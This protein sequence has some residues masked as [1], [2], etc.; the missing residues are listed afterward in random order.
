MKSLAEGNLCRNILKLCIKQGDMKNFYEKIADK[1][2]Q[3]F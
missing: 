3:S 1:T 2:Q